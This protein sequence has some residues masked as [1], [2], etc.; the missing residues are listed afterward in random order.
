MPFWMLIRALA[1]AL[2]VGLGLSAAERPRLPVT[3]VDVVVDR[4][5]GVDV[6]DP[7]RWLED[8]QSSATRAWIDAQNTY[9]RAVLDGVPGRE[10]LRTQIETMSQSDANRM[11]GPIVRGSR[12]FYQRSRPGAPGPSIVVREGLQGPERVLVDA[13]AVTADG[14]LQVQLRHVSADGRTLAYGR[15]RGGSDQ[16][17]IVFLDTVTGE[18]R[19]DRLPSAFYF[20]VFLLPDGSGVL[21]SRRRTVET[22]VMEHRF[23]TPA[24]EDQEHF[25][26]GVA[27]RS[28]L[29]VAY[30]E[31]GRFVAA[32][33]S[34]QVHLWDRS[35]PGGFQF[36]ASGLTGVDAVFGG[37]TLYLR[38]TSGAR[39]GRVLAIDPARPAREHWREVIPEL[40]GAEISMIR[41]A[42]GKLAVTLRGDTSNQLAV[43][44][45]DGRRLRD[46]SLP[47]PGGAF[48]WPMSM[49]WDSDEAFY[50]F[51]SLAHPISTFRVDLSTG[52]QSVWSGPA[53]PAD[54]GAITTSQVW[55]SSKDGTKVPMLVVARRG[56]AFDGTRPTLLAGYGAYGGVRLPFFEPLASAW[57][58]S[59]GVYALAS[60]RGGG[61]LGEQWHRDGMLDRK[62]NGFDDFIAA[63]EWLIANKYTRPDRLA[64]R[65]TSAGGMLVAVAAMQ[66]PDLFAAVVSRNAHL[67]MLRYHLFLQA[68]PWVKEFGN[69]DVAEEF[70]YL[71]RYSP[72]HQVRAGV[73]YPGMLFM[74]GD[75]DTRVAPLHARKMTARLQAASRGDR[76]ILLRYDLLAGHS[77]AGSPENMTAMA[78]DELAFLLAQV[79]QEPYS[80]NGRR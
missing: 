38:T 21:Y 58:D 48:F 51:S 53:T 32:F 77:G 9:T 72:Y 69:P 3:R 36:V 44:D 56:I 27:D 50:F 16:S 80:S 60:I 67:D 55:Y 4:M 28:F 39:R 35:K 57:V 13:A 1:G 7:Y 46:L 5:H 18:A 34:S 66:R 70:A 29:P 12:Y 65:G 43:F 11:D 20:S 49:R 22:R 6:P 54:S 71:R 52:R 15:Q 33:D 78:V 64:I 17:E 23:G 19:A 24:G 40:P 26:A 25:G 63:A 75:N 61:E 41:A 68:A 2:L 31:D 42:G 30:S 76:P 14:S 59:G 79:G 45:L 10:R 73:R 62:Q 47:A 8:Q 74:T 37:Q